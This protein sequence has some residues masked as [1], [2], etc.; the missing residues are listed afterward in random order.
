MFIISPLSN[1]S[2]LDFVRAGFRFPGSDRVTHNFDFSSL[3]EGSFLSF[4]QT[5][6]KHFRFALRRFFNF[7]RRR[8]N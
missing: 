8:A 6:L 5:I 7:F 2:Y 1:T 4:P 3:S